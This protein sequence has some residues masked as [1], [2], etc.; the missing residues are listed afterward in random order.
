LPSVARANLVRALVEKLL[1]GQVE[2][3]LDVGVLGQGGA[4][5]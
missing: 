4:R 5:L 1:V 3:P 2:R